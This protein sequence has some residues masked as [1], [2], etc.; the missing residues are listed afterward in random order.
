[1]GTHLGYFA[2]R[3]LDF[4]EWVR[5][6]IISAPAEWIGLLDMAPTVHR[7]RLTV[8]NCHLGR[9]TTEKVQR[10]K[11][12]IVECPLLLKEQLKRSRMLNLAYKHFK[13]EWN[14]YKLAS[15]N[16]I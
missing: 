8:S 2:R 14:H 6:E 10:L 16:R 13:A 12:N 11:A 15:E 1:M 4:G 9:L 3:L 5:I 7:I